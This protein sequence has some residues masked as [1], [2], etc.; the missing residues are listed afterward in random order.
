MV[1]ILTLAVRELLLI[2]NWK[3]GHSKRLFDVYYEGI[4]QSVEEH[5]RLFHCFFCCFSST[6]KFAL[7]V[8]PILVQCHISMPPENVRKRM[9][10]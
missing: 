3:I 6:W 4:T 2:A 8:E 5:C 1:P 7:P 10:F 9:V